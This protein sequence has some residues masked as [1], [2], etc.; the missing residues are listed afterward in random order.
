MLKSI[1]HDRTKYRLIPMGI[2][3]KGVA[4]LITMNPSAMNVHFELNKANIKSKDLQSVFSFADVIAEIN[5]KTEQN[6]ISYS[7]KDLR[8]TSIEYAYPSNTTSR[9]YSDIT[10][11]NFTEQSIVKEVS[12]S[13]T[14]LKTTGQINHFV[15]QDFFKVKCSKCIFNCY[16]TSPYLDRNARFNLGLKQMVFN[17]NNTQY[18]PSVL[19]PSNSISTVG[20]Q[21][22]SFFYQEL[23]KCMEA[24]DLESE[25]YIKKKNFAFNFD[26][27]FI[28]ALIFGKIFGVTTFADIEYEIGYHDILNNNIPYHPGLRDLFTQLNI[29]AGTYADNLIRVV[30]AGSVYVAAL[31]TCQGQVVANAAQIAAHGGGGV[32]ANADYPAIMCLN[33]NQADAVALVGAIDKIIQYCANESIY[34]MAFKEL[35]ESLAFKA[36]LTSTTLYNTGNIRGEK[37]NK[38]IPKM[39]SK[40]I[41]ALRLD[42]ELTNEEGYVPYDGID[43]Y[44]P[45]SRTRVDLVFLDDLK[46]NMYY[47]LKGVL[48]RANFYFDTHAKYVLTSEGRMEI[49]GN[50]LETNV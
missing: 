2:F 3:P 15:S 7:I 47:F 40:A 8:I 9:F 35:I 13:E 1:G 30:P 46:Q 32:H 42:K 45:Q 37:E 48:F 38:I 24:F 29:V 10:S 12:G 33:D 25:Y 20:D 43:I 17:I 36:K 16:N 26:T 31:F 18:P 28:A 22:C 39:T 23:R 44:G 21:N 41:F 34:D 27:N 6:S 49:Y 5:G 19:A 11:G 14:Y 4:I 50:K